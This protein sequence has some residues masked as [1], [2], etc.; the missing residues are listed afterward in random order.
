MESRQRTTV[1]QETG[2][3]LDH[4]K[5]Y[6]ETK[7]EVTRLTI[8]DKMSTAAGIVLGG[9]I[10]GCLFFLFFIFLGIAVAYIIGEYSGHIYLG[11]ISV[12]GFYLVAGILFVMKKE[13]WIQKPLADKIISNY[14]DDNESEEDQ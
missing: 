7:S 9:L 2:E 10:I 12:A 4:I 5:D 14:F 6:I 1:E 3:L 8:L 11:F 13:Q